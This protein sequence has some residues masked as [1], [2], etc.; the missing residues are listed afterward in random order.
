MRQP[1]IGLEAPESHNDLLVVPVVPV[2]NSLA[3]PSVS[4][5]PAEVPEVGVLNLS[6]YSPAF[7]P[8]T[9]S[10]MASA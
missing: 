1:L 4:S 8:T 9:R 5:D 2:R 7:V 6:I 3:T 10:L